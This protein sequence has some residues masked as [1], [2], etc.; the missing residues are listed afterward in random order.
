MAELD[1]ANKSRDPWWKGARG[2]WLVV[3]QILLIAVVFFGPR[4]FSTLPAWHSPYTELGSIVG[5]SL[6]LVGVLLLGACIFEL[7]A[8]LTPLPQPR[9]R[10]TLIVSGPYRFIRHPMYFGGILIALGWALWVHGWL[11]LGYATALL[12]FAEFKS[13]YEET[14]LR[15]KFPEYAEYEARTRRLIPLL[16]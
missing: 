9:E 6:M 11:T 5:P 15:K 12:I 4:S 8:N 1:T 14:W 3:I 2:E 13:R 7:K 10:S 16:H